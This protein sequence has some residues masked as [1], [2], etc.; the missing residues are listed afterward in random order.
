MSVAAWAPAGQTRRAA[1]PRAAKVQK[2]CL[3][4]ISHLLHVGRAPRAS[5]P[6][7]AMQGFCHTGALLPFLPMALTPHFWTI[8][9][10]LRHSLRPIVC[11]A[12]EPWLLPVADPRM[13]TLHLS[14]ELRDRPESAEALVVVHG[15]G[16]ATTSHYMLRAAQAAE[17]AG[18]TCLRLNLRGSDLRGEDYYHAGLTVDLHATLAAPELASYR[19][20]YLLGY[21]VGGHLV[22]RAAT[23]AAD[24]RLV[25]VAAICPPLA[26]ALSSAAFATPA[27]WLYRPSTLGNLTRPYAAMAARHPL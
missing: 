6:G 10:R 23:E 20:L 13:G 24:P 17:A 11:P 15:L 2:D 8:G 26:L 1:R 4:P 7:P 9:P 19:R 12:G 3:S 25:A 16:G 21:S 5:S 27:L 14:G 18:L 22:L